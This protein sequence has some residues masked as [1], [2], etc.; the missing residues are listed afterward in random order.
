[1]RWF[2]ALSERMRDVRV[3]CGEWDRVLG[4]SVT[5]KH[6]MTGMF[7]DPPYEDNES[8]YAAKSCV[9]EDVR[10]WCVENGSNRLLRIALC[11]YEGEHEMP[12]DWECV[13]WKARKG[14]QKVAEDGTHGG[15]R[16]RIW[17]SPHCLKQPTLFSPG[18]IT[19]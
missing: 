3:C 13:S 2:S 5:V 14:Y 8:V 11:S 4:E 19:P 15:H 7:L 6:G 18:G 16:E 10:Q 17:F 12:D 9:S 1:M